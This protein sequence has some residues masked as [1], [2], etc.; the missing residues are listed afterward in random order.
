MIRL[1]LGVAILCSSEL[2][3]I[4][5]AAAFA[6][7][8]VAALRRL[9]CVVFLLIDNASVCQCVCE[10]EPVSV[11]QATVL[12]LSALALFITHTSRCPWQ[13]QVQRKKRILDA[14]QLPRSVL[15]SR[16]LQHLSTKQQQARITTT[17]SATFPGKSKSAEKEKHREK[18]KGKERERWRVKAKQ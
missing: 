5:T 17:N 2:T 10:C 6:E 13:R 18:E 7:C 3:A 15:V 8:Q 1:A 12:S 11:A 14:A 9:C 4:A 16:N